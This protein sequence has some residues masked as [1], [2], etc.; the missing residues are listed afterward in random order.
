M[1]IVAEDIKHLTASQKA[2]LY[3]FLLD[4]QELKDYL[5]SNNGLAEEIIRSERDRKRDSFIFS[6]SH[7]AV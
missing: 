1:A 2:A 7:L 5:I 4:D 6:E 3:Y